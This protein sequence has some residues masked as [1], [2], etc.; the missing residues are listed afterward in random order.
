MYMSKTQK[1]LA[2]L[3]SEADAMKQR[4][5]ALEQ[6]LENA[7]KEIAALKK[8]HEPPVDNR[9]WYHLPNNW[10]DLL[11]QFARRPD[12]DRI[13]C[14]KAGFRGKNGEALFVRLCRDWA[15]RGQ[16][17]I[18]C[19]R[20]EPLRVSEHILRCT[21]TPQDAL[22]YLES[23]E[24][25]RDYGTSMERAL[26]TCS[27]TDFAVQPFLTAVQTLTGENALYYRFTYKGFQACVR[28]NRENDRY[29]VL[30]GLTC[31]TS[32]SEV[33]MENKVDLEKIQ[34]RLSDPH[35][36]CDLFRYLD[37]MLDAAQNPTT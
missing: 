1:E 22:R 15:S 17:V 32:H 34:K 28:T 27:D 30:A 10:K 16:C 23:D 9:P 29:Q 19:G 12:M 36:S 25:V 4:L 20:I 13:S 11:V 6:A 18:S 7:N 33:T 5:E 37:R 8:F 35:F 26:P 21:L 3:R 14:W 2:A 24:F 31:G